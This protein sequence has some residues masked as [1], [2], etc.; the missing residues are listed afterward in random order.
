MVNNKSSLVFDFDHS[1]SRELEGFYSYCQ[2]E[3]SPAPQFL[4]LNHALAEELGLDI[5]LLGSDE[6]LSILS[7]NCLPESSR[8]LAQAYAGHQFGGFSPLLGDGRALLLG[9]V[10]DLKKQRR[11]IQLKGSGRTPYSRNGDGKSALGPVLREYLISESMH[12]LCIPTTRSLAAVATGEKVYRDQVLPGGI[13]TRVASSHIR[14]GTFQYAASLRDDNKIK[15]IADYTIAR[16]YPEI[17]NE[18]QPYLSLFDKVSHAQAFLVAR[19]M[20]VGFIHGVMNTDNMT[21]SGEAI[22]YGPCAFMDRY[23]PKTVFSSIDSQGR[24]AYMNQ[25]IVLSWNL[26]RLAETLLSLIDPLQDRAVEILT[27]KIEKIESIYEAYWL[28]E[29]RSKIGLSLEDVSDAALIHD[30]LAMMEKEH[31]DF[32]L[33]FRGLAKSLIGNSNLVLEL[34]SDH[35]EFE[36]WMSRWRKR[37]QMENIAEETIANKMN[38]VNPIYIPRNHLVEEAINMAVVEGDMKLYSDLLTVLSHPF[39]EVAEWE[40]YALP[41]PLSDAAYKTFCGT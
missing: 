31:T 37:I 8:P 2:S 34:L 20:S 29:M 7:G 18:E 23:D 10:L 30:L 25:P 11:D 22:D 24:Y 9:E 19:W 1:F 14:I 33:V 27:H 38:R 6:G 39:D 5:N 36:S 32:T 12:T 41:A 3:P 40:L 35:S 28:N 16:H 15:E 21:V 17:I 13:L 4:F 26:A